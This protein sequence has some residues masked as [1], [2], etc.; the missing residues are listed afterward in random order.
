M[1]IFIDGAWFDSFRVQIFVVFVL[2]PDGPA[3]LF[4]SSS[5]FVLLFQDIICVLSHRIDNIFVILGTWIK[6]D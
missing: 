5:F 6:T 3:Q 2:I 4:Q 1:F